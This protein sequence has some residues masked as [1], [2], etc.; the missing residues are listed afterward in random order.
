VLIECRQLNLLPRALH[1]F[2]A[3]DIFDAISG[4]LEPGHAFGRWPGP[5]LGSDK[6]SSSS[7]RTPCLAITTSMD[8][9]TFGGSLLNFHTIAEKLWLVEVRGIL[10]SK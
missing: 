9:G 10:A 4:A 3:A 2:T 6:P 5:S 1:D 7:E 8:R